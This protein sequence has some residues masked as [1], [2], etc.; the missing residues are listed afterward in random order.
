MPMTT[1]D[2]IL[3]YLK[4]LLSAPPVAGVVA[5]L[6]LILFRSELR[7]LITRIATI[8]FPGGE[9]STSQE[10]VAE[11]ITGSSDTPPPSSDAPN[12]PAGLVL[13]PEQQQ[14]IVEFV[15]AERARAALWEYRFLNFYL[16]RH[17]QRILDWL[18]S[19]KKP[20]T[21]S[22]FDDFWSPSIPK[23]SERRAIIEALE[24][25]RLIQLGGPF[26][27]VTPKGREYLQWRGPLPEPPQASQGA[28]KGGDL[29]DRTG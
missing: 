18:A 14:K 11:K 7:N 26:I 2:L 4:V 6:C 13:G 16:V 10:S 8:R 20:V 15:E 19:L 29:E 12:L 23:P 21:L 27:E 17:T 3:N 22:L 9:L 25:N 24:N 5:A 28:T 1:A